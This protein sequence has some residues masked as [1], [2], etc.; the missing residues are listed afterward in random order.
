MNALNNNNNYL[1]KKI[2]RPLVADTTVNI[3]LTLFDIMNKNKLLPE[4]RTEIT[5]YINTVFEDIN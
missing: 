1:T 5:N 3:V 4:E 2:D